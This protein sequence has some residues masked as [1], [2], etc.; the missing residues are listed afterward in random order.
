MDY[1]NFLYTE[2]NDS[3]NW[4]V[5]IT[6]QPDLFLSLPFGDGAYNEDIINTENIADTW[7]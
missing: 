5:D 7:E 4:I 3:K 2:L 1:L 6:G